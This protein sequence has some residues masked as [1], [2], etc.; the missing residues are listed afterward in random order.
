[1]Q[2]RLLFI[3]CCGYPFHNCQ[4]SKLLNSSGLHLALVISFWPRHS[5]NCC[6]TAVP[7]PSGFNQTCL[8]LQLNCSC[9]TAA[10]RRSVEATVPDGSS[11][12]AAAARFPL[13][14]K[15][16][17]TRRLLHE[18][19]KYCFIEIFFFF[20][21]IHTAR[22][23]YGNNKMCINKSEDRILHYSVAT[24]S[25]YVIGGCTYESKTKRKEEKSKHTC[26]LS[27]ER[28]TLVW[29][30]NI[31]IWRKR[32]FGSV[33]TVQQPGVRKS[34]QLWPVTFIFRGL[35]GLSVYLVSFA[36]WVHRY[37]SRNSFRWAG[38]TCVWLR[39]SG[40]LFQCK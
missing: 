38:G 20:F 39:A 14:H 33:A 11:L 9:V 29:A 12:D 10:A 23:I 3:K 7:E 40:L 31:W 28:E 25:R 1:M 16:A 26:A 19:I 27:R 2:N 15:E 6:Q 17:L 37:E 8:R 24:V 30:R 36:C 32:C 34:K 21:S 22:V 5:A 18:Q 4:G 13:R 35:I